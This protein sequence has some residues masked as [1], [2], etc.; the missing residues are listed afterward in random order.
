MRMVSVA[1][2]DLR[3]VLEPREDHDEVLES[4]ERQRPREEQER[5]RKLQEGIAAESTERVWSIRDR[6]GSGRLRRR[7]EPQS[8]RVRYVVIG[9]LAAQLRSF[10]LPRSFRLEAIGLMA[11]PAAKTP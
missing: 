2:F 5:W 3:L 10:T 7:V 6:S 8:A 11:N 1:G 9:A 4:L